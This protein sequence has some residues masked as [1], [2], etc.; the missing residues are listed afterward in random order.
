MVAWIVKIITWIIWNI[1]WI[2]IGAIWGFVLSMIIFLLIKG[3]ENELPRNPLVIR[4]AQTILYILGVL[5]LLKF[6]S[7]PY[8]VGYLLGCFSFSNGLFFDVKPFLRKTFLHE[9]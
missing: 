7:Y 6:G 1:L 2:I 9:E 4:I 8:L 5:L 3:L